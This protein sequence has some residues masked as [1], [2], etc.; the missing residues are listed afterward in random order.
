MPSQL[1]NTSYSIHIDY[2]FY[3][4]QNHFLNVEL[5]MYTSCRDKSTRRRHRYKEQS[6]RVTILVDLFTIFQ[7]IRWS[8]LVSSL[9]NPEKHLS[10]ISVSF[11]T[12]PG[13]LR[14][15][16]WSSPYYYISRVNN[17]IRRITEPITCCRY[18]FV[19]YWGLS[20]IK[21]LQLDQ[22]SIYRF[23]R[24][25]NWQALWIGNRA[26]HLFVTGYLYKDYL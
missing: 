19:F 3:Q 16:W 23:H 22:W 5:N 6:C 15:R 25:P 24:K 13:F 20:Y 9:Y 8:L 11:L 10:I 18:S 7:L 12:L 14:K 2:Y 17:L 26:I 1:T 21:V 4:R